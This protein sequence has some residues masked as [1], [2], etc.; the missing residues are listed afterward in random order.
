[1]GDVIEF[2]TRA[3]EA[4]ADGWTAALCQELRERARSGSAE[5]NDLGFSIELNYAIAALEMIADNCFNGGQ[6]EDEPCFRQHFAARNLAAIALCY[7]KP[8]PL[9]EATPTDPVCSACG[10][11]L[12]RGADIVAHEMARM[13]DDSVTSGVVIGDHP[14]MCWTCANA[15]AAARRQEHPG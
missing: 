13:H 1:M 4:E 11:P 12:A 14:V 8:P 2:V 10:G 3:A 9:P 6:S 15:F 7:C 5:A